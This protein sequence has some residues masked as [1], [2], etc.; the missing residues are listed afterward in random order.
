MEELTASDKSAIERMIRKEFK[1]KEFE[2]AFLR[3]YKNATTSFYQTMYTRRNFWR[4][5]LNLRS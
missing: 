2:E 3:L 4:D 1:E 5:S